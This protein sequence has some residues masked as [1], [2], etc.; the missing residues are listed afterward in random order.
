MIEKQA[1]NLALRFLGAVTTADV[2]EVI[3]SDP[4]FA[5]PDNWRP[6]GGQGK[7]WDRVS[8][9]TSNAVGALAELIINS[10]DAILMRKFAESEQDGTVGGDLKS[11]TDAVKR[12]FPYVVE[13]KIA[14]LSPQQRTAL[15][16]KSVVIG[17]KRGKG[18]KKFPTYTL[19]DFGEG[20]NAP[21]RPRKISRLW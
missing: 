11:M 18:S 8:A 12:F 13:G 19:A 1:K 20:R 17:V 3:A 5:A 9:Q 16:G 21:H 10:V 14:S 15:A 7:N 4:A 2:N 6:Y